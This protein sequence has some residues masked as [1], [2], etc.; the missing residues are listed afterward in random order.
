MHRFALDQLPVTPWKNGGGTTREI[1]C[2]PPGASMDNFDW[3]ISIATIEQSGPFSAFPGIDRVIMLLDG[4]GVRLRAGEINHCLDTSGQPFAFSGDL[5]LDCEL[6]GG[7][8]TDFNVM[9]RRNS[10]RAEVQVVT[11]ARQIPPSAQG[12][13]MATR[14]AWHLQA[15]AH[16]FQCPGGHGLWWDVAAS[17]QATPIEANAQLIWVGLYGVEEAKR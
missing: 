2:L 4:A 15:K 10:L 7:P 8:S 1:L 11:E 12:L 3:R 9:S 17:W 14:G 6:L 16:D 13:L 5:S